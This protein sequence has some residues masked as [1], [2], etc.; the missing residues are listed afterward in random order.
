MIDRYYYKRSIVTKLELFSFCSHQQSIKIDF[1]IS[2]HKYLSILFVVSV[3]EVANIVCRAEAELDNS[4]LN[5]FTTLRE[6]GSIA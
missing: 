5:K 6:F 1:K 2:S 4:L 3:L